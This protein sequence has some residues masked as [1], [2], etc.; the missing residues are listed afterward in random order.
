MKKR[1]GFTQ[2]RSGAG[3]TLIELIIYIALGT[4]IMSV[5]LSFV[6]QILKAHAYA[7]A[8]ESTLDG[9]ERALEIMN[10]EIR[11]ADSV[12]TP[13]SVFGNATGQLGLESAIDLPA[14]EETSFVDFYLDDGKLYQKKE[15]ANAG[16]LTP[17]L[18]ITNLTFTHL[19]IASPLPAVRISIT[20]NYDSPSAE[21]QARSQISLS[22]TVSLRAY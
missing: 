1:S 20:A 13:T 10:Y 8:K 17:N 19:N 21:I 14:G 2:H 4:I 5:I 9:V 11:H 18:E 7:Q 16:L 12:Y 15:G 22:S 3:F 6:P